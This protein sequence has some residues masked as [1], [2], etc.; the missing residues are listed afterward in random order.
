MCLKNA[1]QDEKYQD[2][3]VNYLIYITKSQQK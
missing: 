1:E 2:G 3:P